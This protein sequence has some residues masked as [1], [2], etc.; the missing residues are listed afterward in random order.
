M[1]GV[2]STQEQG[3]QVVKKA[4]PGCLMPLSGRKER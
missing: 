4:A 2:I 3:Y 1:V